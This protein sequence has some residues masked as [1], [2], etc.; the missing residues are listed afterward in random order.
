M[1]ISCVEEVIPSDEYNR[2]T[3]NSGLINSN[4]PRKKI[5]IIAGFKQQFSLPSNLN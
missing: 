4:F 1:L 2:S 3:R 5:N